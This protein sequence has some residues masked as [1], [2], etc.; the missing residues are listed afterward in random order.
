MNQYPFASDRRRPLIVR[1]LRVIGGVAVILGAFLGLTYIGS[2]GWWWS[3][4]G[5]C[6]IVAGGWIAWPRTW[7][8][9]LGLGIG[10]RRLVL[11]GIALVCALAVSAPLILAI[12]HSAG[13]TFMPKYSFDPGPMGYMQTVGQ[14]LNEELVLGAILLTAISKLLRR[15]PTIAIA[16]LVAGVFSV[17][18]Y[19]FYAYAVQGWNRGI[20]SVASL[21]SL[22]I[23]GVIRNHLILS[24]GHIGYAWALHLGWNAVF[25]GGVF[26]GRRVVLNEPD[27]FNLFLG[28]PYV[29]ATV[30]ALM[31]AVVL[32]ARP[33]RTC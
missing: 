2:L 21:V 17:L 28:S 19:V 27:C 30:T 7:R 9:W 23:A 8:Q 20:L 18:H 32:A 16:V 24:T 5:S 10:R 29:L 26:V 11:T 13:V 14:T 3:V 6:L 22:F 1:T 15:A 33:P 12:A 25:M 4:T 31:I